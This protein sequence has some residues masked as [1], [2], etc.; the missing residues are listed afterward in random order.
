MNENVSSK[1]IYGQNHAKQDIYA[2]C[3]FLILY[4]GIFSSTILLAQTYVKMFALSIGH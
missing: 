3:F 2:S 1:Y 4:L